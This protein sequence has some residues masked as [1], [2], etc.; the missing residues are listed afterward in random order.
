ME[1][2]ELNINKN[3]RSNSQCTL[4]ICRTGK[5]KQ[6]YTLYHEGVHINDYG[7]NY[8]CDYNGNLSYNFEKAV[9]KA[10]V[11]FNEIV[12]CGYWFSVGI[13]YHEEPRLIYNRV[14]AFGMTFKTAKSGKVMWGIANSDFWNHWKKDK[15]KVKDAGFWVKKV[16][17][18]WMV[19]CKIEA[20]YAD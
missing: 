8:F 20:Q 2:P 19:F 10:I 1:L 6:Y 18:Q 14:E 12:D 11:R 13:E 17:Y 16:D 7:G 15:Q 4:H 9:K 3:A 5:K